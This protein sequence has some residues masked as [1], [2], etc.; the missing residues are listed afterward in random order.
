MNPPRWPLFVALGVGL[1]ALVF[2]AVGGWLLYD[3]LSFQGTANAE[4][5]V[6]RLE[7]HNSVDN[8]NRPQR[9][10]T[11]VVHFQADGRTVEIRSRVA[12]SPPPYNVGDKVHV[13]Y[14]PGQPD[15][16]RIESFRENYLLPVIFLPIGGLAT[17]AA[18][19][20]YAI[21]LALH[22]RRMFVLRNGTPVQAKVVEIRIDTSVKVNG[23]SPWVLAAEYHDN[24]LMQTHRFTSH[25][26]WADPT[27]RYPVGGPVTVFYLPDKPTRHAFPI[28]RNGVPFDVGAQ[29]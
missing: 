26:L 6:D 5:V 12:S 8:K 28:D 20:T 1:L 15:Q 11:T 3:A 10:A 21:P 22:R 29:A 16:G 19:C 13:Q 25:Y 17:L 4:G 23:R 27:P 9:S 18:V 7:W 2:D 24:G 14:P